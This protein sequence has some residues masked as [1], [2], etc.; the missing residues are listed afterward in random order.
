[1]ITLMTPPAGG[2]DDN[3]S[4]FSRAPA[5]SVCAP[6]VAT[7]AVGTAVTS[8][9]FNYALLVARITENIYSAFPCFVCALLAAEIAQG[10][11]I[12]P[13]VSH[14]AAS[15]RDCQLFTYLQLL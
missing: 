5:R 2:T 12:T 1:M 11:V 9:K 8:L 7:T 6:L 4:S 10:I 14:L 3:S 15:Q 13:S